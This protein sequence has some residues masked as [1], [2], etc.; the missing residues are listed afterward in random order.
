MTVGT[1]GCVLVA[2]EHFHPVDRMLVLIIEDPLRG[3]DRLYGIVTATTIDF[4]R[5]TVRYRDDIVMTVGAL[6]SGMHGLADYGVSNKQRN[7]TAGLLGPNQIG[8]AVTDGAF[9]YRLRVPR[10]H[11]QHYQAGHKKSRESFDRHRPPQSLRTRRLYS[12]A[13]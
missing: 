13:R 12:R 6:A 7:G 8:P 2:F 5:V 11:K 1:H 4:F 3:T 9:L 10:A